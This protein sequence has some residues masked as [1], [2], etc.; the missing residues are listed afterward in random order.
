MFEGAFIENNLTELTYERTETYL[1]NIF[2]KCPIRIICAFTMSE[3]AI[4]IL[5]SDYINKTA[6]KLIT[7]SVNIPF[8]AGDFYFHT[9]PGYYDDGEFDSGA[10]GK[11]YAE[12]LKTKKI[13]DEPYYLVHPRYFKE[14][15]E[16]PPIGPH[17]TGELSTDISIN[18]IKFYF[19]RDVYDKMDDIMKF[20][21]VLLIKNEELALKMISMIDEDYYEIEIIECDFVES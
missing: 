18:K 13:A 3:S 21:A 2:N 7:Y 14:T 15:S 11:M 16:E 6:K 20:K 12:F 8:K 4:Q 5:Q 1:I 9:E 17:Y 10:Y 19:T